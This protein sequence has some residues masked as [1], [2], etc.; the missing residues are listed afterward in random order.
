MLAGAGEVGIGLDAVADIG[1][2]EK[3]RPFG[4]RLGILL[5][6][7]AGAQHRGVP[8]L[9]AANAVAAPVAGRGEAGLLQQRFFAFG[10][11]ALL[12]F[13]DETVVTVEIDKSAAR[14]AVGIVKFYGM[15]E[16]VFVVLGL[17]GGR[18]RVR[19]PE[20]IAKLDQEELIIGP[21]GGG[22]VP[23]ARDKGGNRSLFFLG[24]IVLRAAA[25]NAKLQR[26]Q[27][28]VKWWVKR[29]V[30]GGPSI[31]R[32]APRRLA[33]IAAAF[34]LA[35]AFARP[36][37]AAAAPEGGASGLVYVVA[38][39]WHTELD[40]PVA[41]IGGPLAALEPAGARY[42]V[43]GW[44][45]QDY[46]MARDPGLADLLRAAAPGPAVMLVVPLT[47]PPQA[48]AGADNVWPVAVSR[49][50]ARRLSQFLWESLAKDPRGAPQRVGAGPYPQSVVLC[51]SR[52][53][54]SHAHLQHLDRRGIA[55]GRSA[56]H[57]G[58]GGFCRPAA[59]PIAA[60]V[61]RH[62]AG[63]AGA[64]ASHLTLP[65]PPLRAEREK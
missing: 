15:L 43:L 18:H 47:V 11:A 62:R 21:L 49:D 9:G 50:G 23:P 40:L 4:Q 53:L 41:A 30:D 65:S 51:R 58:R 56:G 48:F 39:G 63:P 44:G 34:L 55:R 6:L 36:S 22:R 60:A 10:L 25:H 57:R 19:Q 12:G 64:P 45:A 29:R 33:G 16:P 42:L 3:R 1:D 61:K 5:G 28:W 46:Y 17:A 31:L 52:P 8:G 7:A 37:A 13:E 26:C 32:S 14:R 35:G 54:R 59:R 20:H 24:W 2:D 27:W 38:G